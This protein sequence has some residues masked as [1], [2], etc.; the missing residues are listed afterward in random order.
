M[1]FPTVDS[2]NKAAQDFLL[3]KNIK[4]SFVINTKH[5]TAGR[6]QGSNFWESQKGKNFAFSLV[7][8]PDFLKAKNQFYL[9]KAI[10]LGIIDYL[11]TIVENVSIKW[12]NDIY[13]GN[14]KI[15]G[16][17]IE[18]SIQYDFISNSVIGVGLNVNQ[19]YFFSDAP[20]PTSLIIETGKELNL[21]E[22][23]LKIL[24]ALS[25]RYFQLKCHEFSKLDNDYLENLFGLNEIRKFRNESGI[26]EAKIIGVNSIGQLL[27]EN[28]NEKLI[29][30][31]GELNFYFD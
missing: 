4:E 24:D 21:D 11:K 1:F 15:A 9:L 23:L 2:T 7:V 29:Y 17:L 22:E 6:G 31:Y 28:K 27:L 10:S 19:N 3:K 18:N 8:F 16:I 30:N 26:F 20:N 25:D 13:V 12:T 14:K 5:Q